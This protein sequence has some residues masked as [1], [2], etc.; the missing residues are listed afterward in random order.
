MK[1]GVNV[2]AKF[3]A[4]GTALMLNTKIMNSVPH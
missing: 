4:A 3:G 2:L 1:D